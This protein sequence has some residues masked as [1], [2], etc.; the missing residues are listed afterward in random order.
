VLDTPVYEDH[1]AS[2][3]GE[4]DPSQPVTDVRPQTLAY[5]RLF[6]AMKRLAAWMVPL[7]DGTMP[8]RVCARCGSADRV[9]F[10]EQHTLYHSCDGL[11]DRDKND[12]GK[13]CAECDAENNAYWDEMWREHRSSQG[14]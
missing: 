14:V 13:L 8:A 11:L 4:L 1:Y 2:D 6:W 12:A 3:P 7:V 5:R 10:R 9:D